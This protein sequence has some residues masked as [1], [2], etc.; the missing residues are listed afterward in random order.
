MFVQY[1]YIILNVVWIHYIKFECVFVFECIHAVLCLYCY[2]MC[3]CMCHY[4]GRAQAG[5]RIGCSCGPV[6]WDP[7]CGRS[8]RWGHQPAALASAAAAWPAGTALPMSLWRAQR[9]NKARMTI[10][11]SSDSAQ[12]R[13]HQIRA[14]WTQT[15][16]DSTFQLIHKTGSRLSHYETFWFLKP[17]LNVFHTLKARSV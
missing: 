17:L 15:H 13:H 5:W 4:P 6:R 9:D 7:V 16:I 12:T 1:E 14:L 10:N 8:C 11:S 2:G 3:V